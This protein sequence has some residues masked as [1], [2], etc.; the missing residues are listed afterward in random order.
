LAVVWTPQSPLADS[1]ALSGVR[2][3]AS[4]YPRM[5]IWGS[6]MFLIASFVGG[7]ILAAT[8]PQ[9]VPVMMSAGLLAAL[10]AT[11]VAPRLGPPRRAYHL[12]AT[13]LRDAAPKLFNRYFLLFVAGSD[14]INASHGFLFGF[15]SIFWKSIGISDGMIG[16]LWAWAVVA[17]VGIFMV[18]NR[19]FGSLSAVAVLSVAGAA[20]ILRWVAY[21]LIAPAGL[22]VAGFFGV[23]TLHALSTGML[24]IG[25]QKMIGETAPEERTG[26]AQGVAFFAVGV[27]MATVTLLSGP[28]YER[29]GTSGFYAMAAVAAVGL[30]LIAAAAF[31]P[32]AQARAATPENPDS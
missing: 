30:A 4:S 17:E 2:R 12:S 9:S 1:L 10:A 16:M 23:Q 8:S 18:F 6:L 31:S 14:I 5:R 3:F 21:P 22:G 24:L 15:V 26:A 13:E 20:A 19:L 29:I 32:R 27:S 28:L 25:L 11:L 7:M